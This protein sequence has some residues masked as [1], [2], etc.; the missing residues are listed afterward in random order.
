MHA[1]LPPKST[2]SKRPVQIKDCDASTQTQSKPVYDGI[3]RVL[4]R[5]EGINAFEAGHVQTVEVNQP[6]LFLP[7]SL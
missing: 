3:Q 4:W 7:A 5:S 2:G 6:G 1:P